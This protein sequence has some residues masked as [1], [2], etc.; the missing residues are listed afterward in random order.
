MSMSIRVTPKTVSTSITPNPM[1]LHWPQLRA[2][3]IANGGC[4]AC[5]GKLERGAKAFAI[6]VLGPDVRPMDTS[7]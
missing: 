3:L 5:I 6:R 4:P 1:A 7:C 2:Q